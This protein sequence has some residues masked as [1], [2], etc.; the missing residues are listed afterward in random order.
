MTWQINHGLH[1]KDAWARALVQDTACA[2]AGGSLTVSATTA[3]LTILPRSHVGSC[4][5]HQQSDR[6]LA[7]LNNRE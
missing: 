1:F 2:A 7:S 4:W 5:L 6:S 3:S